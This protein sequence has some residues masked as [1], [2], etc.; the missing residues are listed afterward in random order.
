MKIPFRYYFCVLTVRG[1]CLCLSV[2][3]CSPDSRRVVP[4]FLCER[5]RRESLGHRGQCRPRESLTDRESSTGSK[6]WFNFPD[7]SPYN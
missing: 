5:S 6:N 7:L 2:K 3:P 1:L 4:V